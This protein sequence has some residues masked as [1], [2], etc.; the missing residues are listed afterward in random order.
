MRARGNL[1]LIK[2]RWIALAMTC[3]LLVVGC[4]KPRAPE[5][6]PT[7]PA[8]PTRFSHAAH[9]EQGCE[10]C[11]DGDNRPGRS[12]H[13]PCDQGQCHRADFLRPPGELCSN[14]HLEVL[15]GAAGVSAPLQPFPRTTGW[16][17]LP[18]AFSHSKHLDADRVEAAVGFHLACADCHPANEAGSPTHPSHEACARCHAEEV[19]LRQA[20]TMAQC[21]RCHAEPAPRPRNR[22][23]LIK[24]DLHFAHANH[25]ADRAGATIAC[26]TCH[27]DTATTDGY[28]DHKPPAVASCV[29]CHDDAAR[30]PSEQRMRECQTCHS[31]K[32]GSLVALAPRDHLPGTERPI[33]HT[34]SFR[35]DHGDAAFRDA[36]RC[37]TCHTAMSGSPRDA[38]D[39]CHRVT[40]P[41]DHRLSWRELEHGSEAA[42]SP[43]RCALCHNADSC[44]DCHSV[45]PRSHLPLMS[46]R[47]SHGMAARVNLRA[48][49]TCHEPA[50]DC[51]AC[52]TEM[53]AARR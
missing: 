38:C 44:K 36:A 52:H 20:P 12:D 41:F 13:A 17:L 10:P 1:L 6:P 31:G 9:R 22:A 50:Q 8:D 43:E 48:C 34:L 15:V 46:F 47:T 27:L 28:A 7:A 19:G 26:N 37:A 32:T 35:T 39:E 5:P 33:D 18:S 14:C 25:R 21:E 16:R 29:P 11:H 4:G 2:A 3:A 24:G 40:P 49:L 30:V 51:A 42:T 23:R 53:G 45:T